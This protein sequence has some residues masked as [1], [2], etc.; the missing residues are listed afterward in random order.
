LITNAVSIVRTAS[1]VGAF[2]AVICS[3][4]DHF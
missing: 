3:S 2:P 1:V 4:T